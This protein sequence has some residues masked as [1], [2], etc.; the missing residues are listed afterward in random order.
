[1]RTR[2][3]SNGEGNNGVQ[4][5]TDSEEMVWMAT[6]IG[7]IPVSNAPKNE[8]EAE[9]YAEELAEGYSYKETSQEFAKH[10]AGWD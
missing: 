3:W 7:W 1:M 2:Y 4:F 6:N 9:K 8:R 5:R 10:M